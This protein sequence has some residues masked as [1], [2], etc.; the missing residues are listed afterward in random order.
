[1][2]AVNL[3]ELEKQASEI[4][5]TM[6][7]GYYAGGAHDEI[8]LKENHDAYN[9]IELKYRVLVDVS[10]RDMST[11]VCGQKVSMPI[12]I[13]PTAFQ[14]MAHA[15]GELATAKA[16]HKAGTIMVVSTLA[17]SSIEEIRAISDGPLWY[18]L[19]VFKD[20]SITKALVERAEQAGYSALVLTVDLPVSGMRYADVRNSFQLPGHLSM[21][22]L[23]DPSRQSFPNQDGSGLTNYVAGEFDP[24]VTWKDVEWLRSITKMPVLLKGV[25][26]GDDAKK[27]IDHGASGL[28]VSNHGGRQLDTAPATIKALPEIVAAA[29]DKID[30]LIDGGIRRGTDVLKAL[31]LGAKAVLVGRPILWGLA[32]NGQDGVTTVLDMLAKDFDLA[33]ALCGCP[34][35]ADIT[36]DLIG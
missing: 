30:I 13:A 22:N 2:N 16:A 1:M 23:I 7:F 5:P 33:M 17:T 21:K 10:R 29:G 8:T 35:V 6:A 27:A 24:A 14:K 18:Q 28:I 12:L 32:S 26:R 36:G 20:R 15:E 9:R 31:A 34:S 25:I 4:L 11:T 3:Q 19:Y